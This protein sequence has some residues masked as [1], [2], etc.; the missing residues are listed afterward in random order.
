MS[1]FFR[2]LALL[3]SRKRFRSELDEE[4]AFHRAETEKEFVADGLSREDARYAAKRRLGNEGLLKE[5]THGVVAFRFESLFADIRYAIRQLTHSPAFTLVMLLTLGLSIGANSAIFSV[6][7]GVLLKSLPYPHADRLMRLFLSSS[8][9]PKFPLN[10]FDFLDFRARNHSFESMAIFTRGDVQLSGSGVPVRING[11]G[12]SSGYFH[13]LGLE[14]KL[15]REFDRKSEIPGNGLQVILSDRL[16]RTRFDADP[17]II[18]R[19]ITLNMQPFTVV[20]VMPPGVAHPGNE[21]HAVT[22]GESV[23]VWWPFSFAGNPNQRGSHYTEGIARL[24][25]GV[26]VD[27]ASAEMNAIMTQLGREHDGDRD[28]TVLVIPLYTEIVGKSRPMLLVLLGAV[29]MVLL[30]ACANAANLLLAR[31]AS[32]QRE[33]AVRMAVGAPR[34]RVVRQLLTESLL[35]SG[36]GGA[37][38]L[39][40]A[41]VG[42]DLLVALL[43]AD[44][45]RAHDIHVSGPVFAF[46]FLVSMATGVV[47]G[48]IPALQA[49]GADP[50]QGLQSGGRTTAGSA[51]QSRLRSALVISEVSLACVLLIGAGLMLRSLLNQLRLDPG[52]E[53]E[54]LLTANLSLPHERYKAGADI[55]R[56]YQQLDAKLSVLPG[57]DSAGA[58]SDLPWTGWDENM[59][60]FHIEGKQP[61]PGKE[62]HARYHMATPKFFRALGTPLVAGRFFKDSDTATSQPVLIINRAMA[63]RYWPGEDVIGKRMTF[64]DNPKEKDWLTIVGEVGD[65]KDEPNSPSAEPG[66]WW[67]ETQ[68]TNPDMSVAIRSSSNPELLADALR[69]EV[70][71]LDPNLA[72]SDVQV[73]D[74]IVSGSVATPR[75][76]FVLVGMFAALALVL[77]AIGTYGVISY[78]V[79]QRTPEF[80]LR[81]ALGAQQSNVLNLVLRQAA[82]LTITGTIVGIAAS[83]AVARVLKNL[84][85][86]VSPTD[87]ATFAAVALSV[88]VIA[89]VACYIP[90]R[91]ATKA[92]PMSALRAE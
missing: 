65:V 82:T 58:G 57:V 61:P 38:G 16:W 21:Y 33:L 51:H 67:P 63:E 25:D 71:Q 4:M 81:M 37:L 62:F 41:F 11:F 69:N 87:P 5:K 20:G 3:F 92:D 78:S 90:A 59:G 79:S 54:H 23:D 8:T 74:R 50:K 86:H 53:Q 56:F 34:V 17:A 77:A 22:Y 7:D 55:A 70:R 10:P 85:F 75:F 27:Q 64:E 40:L 43:P 76:A 42:V 9:Y 39:A 44:F 52:F 2:K 28:W 91:R 46:T 88:I 19:K 30:I 15:G 32:R 84:I 24:K 36:M 1:S 35:L 66:F 13:V 26:S 73:M 68:G 83:F 31:A 60:G 29:G 12:I 49:A 18:G 45:P 14:P 89:L 80:G 48:M 6:I 72:V 47:F